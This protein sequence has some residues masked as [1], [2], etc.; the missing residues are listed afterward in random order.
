[1]QEKSRSVNLQLI[2]WSGPV[3]VALLLNRLALG[4][5]FLLAGLAKIRMGS[6]VFYREGFTALKPAWFP[7]V[8]ARPYGH[9]LPFLELM[10]GTLL[11][12]GLLSR[13]TAGVIAI[14]LASF[15]VALWAA[16][17]FFQGGGPFHT[18]V[19]FLTLAILLAATG[20]GR[21]SLDYLL[22]RRKIEAAL[23]SAAAPT[24]PTSAARQTGEHRP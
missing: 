14:M 10:V 13:L 20:P 6:G 23:T 12:I 9:A 18:N 3:A 1:M 17:M 5:F 2:G 24:A 22:R 21:Y 7:E 8:F 4:M 19:V 11:V 15:T 16:G